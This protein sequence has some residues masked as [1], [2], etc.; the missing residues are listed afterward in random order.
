M[1]RQIDY[2]FSSP[3]EFAFDVSN[4]TQAKSLIARAN[5]YHCIKYTYPDWQLSDCVEKLIKDENGDLSQVRCICDTLGTIT[6]VDDWNYY[7]DTSGNSFLLYV[8]PPQ[9]N[10]IF[11]VL[12]SVIFIMLLAMGW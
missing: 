10:L 7:Y 9:I 11:F 1:N 6:I 12:E 8:L 5:N 3:I 2:Q 4:Q